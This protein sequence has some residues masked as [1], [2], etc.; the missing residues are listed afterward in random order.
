MALLLNRRLEFGRSA[1]CNIAKLHYPAHTRGGAINAVP[2]GIAGPAS[3][4]FQPLAGIGLVV[5]ASRA[6]GR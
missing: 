3:S 2:A 4:V 1:Q 6:W 5:Q